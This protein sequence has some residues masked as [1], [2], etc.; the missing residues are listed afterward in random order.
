ML[1][2]YLRVSGCVIAFVLAISSNDRVGKMGK[3]KTIA[4]KM[5]IMCIFLALVDSN[6]TLCAVI[7]QVKARQ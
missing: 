4:Y 1:M 2:D 6:I 5:P 3:L 7:A